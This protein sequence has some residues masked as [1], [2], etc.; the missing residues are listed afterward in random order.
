MSE[1]IYFND[2]TT[3]H[4]VEGWYVETALRYVVYVAPTNSWY[5]WVRDFLCPRRQWRRLGAWLDAY[6]L[7]TFVGKPVV[8]I[9]LSMGGAVA[10]YA[11]SMNHRTAEVYTFGSPKPG[12]IDVS[13]VQ[14]T[15]YCWRGDIVPLLPI[16]ARPCSDPIRIGGWKLFWKA[17]AS[18][19]KMLRQTISSLGA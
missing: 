17:H 1:R 7:R 9:G 10:L 6:M 19:G 15:E 12:R 16:F 4:G 14:I 11:S 5:D 2:D 18:Y 13:G 3:K 8:L